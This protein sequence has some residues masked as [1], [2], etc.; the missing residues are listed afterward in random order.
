MDASLDIMCKNFTA[1]AQKQNPL[2][3]ICSKARRSIII[4]VPH[5]GSRRDLS[6]CA[7]VVFSSIKNKKSYEG[8]LLSDA[9]RKYSVLTKVFKTLT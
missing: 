9:F 2:I 5:E 7:F 6:N 8:V 4:S 1:Q 3:F